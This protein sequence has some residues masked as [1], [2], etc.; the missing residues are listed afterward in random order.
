MWQ[1]PFTV[2]IRQALKREEKSIDPS[3]DDWDKAEEEEDNTKEANE[4][5]RDDRKRK[6]EAEE[7]AAK[8]RTGM[9]SMRRS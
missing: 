3:W 9:G 1:P 6:Q 5:A 8:R 7:R 4:Q 2:H